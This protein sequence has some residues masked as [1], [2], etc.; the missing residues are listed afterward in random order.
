MY[1]SLEIL[2]KTGIGGKKGRKDA[3]GKSIGVPPTPNLLQQ[4]EARPLET[5]YL[6][7]ANDIFG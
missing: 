1:S 5:V 7:V 3:V 6:S 2:K 4:Q